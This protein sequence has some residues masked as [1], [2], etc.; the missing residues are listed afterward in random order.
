MESAAPT[1]KPTASATNAMATATTAVA[2]T[3]AAVS[4]AATAVA[5]SDHRN[6][7]G[8]QEHDKSE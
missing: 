2:A 7:D 1:M 6:H 4:A 8:R 3:A 5:V